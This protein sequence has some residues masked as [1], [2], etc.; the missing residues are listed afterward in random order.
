M[1]LSCASLTVKPGGEHAD[2]M[3]EDSDEDLSGSDV[4]GQEAVAARMAQKALKSAQKRQAA[5][6]KIWNKEMEDDEVAAYTGA[7]FKQDGAPLQ[8][9]KQIVSKAR[10][11]VFNPALKELAHIVMQDLVPSTASI[12]NDARVYK[13]SK[14]L[15]AEPPT[16]TSGMANVW[17]RPCS[18]LFGEN[19]HGEPRF[20]YVKKGA[21]E[22]DDEPHPFTAYVER[23]AERFKLTEVKPNFVA[24]LVFAI[25]QITST[26]IPARGKGKKRG[27][28][29]RG[30]IKDVTH[31]QAGIEKA[32]KFMRN[33]DACPT[34]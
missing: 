5:C 2:F 34:E 29:K 6:K 32:L 4:E 25:G 17:P 12:D 28:M 30:E 10:G 20:L 19:E 27:I 8:Q 3:E 1:C 7:F 22:A 31:W 23:V 14:K 13:E 18:L 26:G 21:S 15:L 24:F 33:R 9:M 16:G 11:N